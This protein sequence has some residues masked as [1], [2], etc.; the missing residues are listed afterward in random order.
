METISIILV[1]V[2]VVLFVMFLVFFFSNLKKSKEIKSQ[3]ERIAADA[4]E[5]KS[6][7]E[8]I[9]TDS[10]ELENLRKYQQIKDAEREAKKIINKANINSDKMRS[11]AEGI[12][13]KANEIFARA[14]Q[15]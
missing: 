11:K 9:A 6:Q 5:I 10:I 15:V 7:A 13:L 8:R 3:S 1:V 4:K 12:R 14:Q 2:C